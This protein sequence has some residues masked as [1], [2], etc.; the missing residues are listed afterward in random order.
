MLISLHRRLVFLAMTKTASTSIEEALLPLCHISF[1]RHPK[2]KHISYV[3]YKRFVQPYLEEIGFSG[4]ETTCLIREPIS[5][6][7]SWYKYR[8]RQEILGQPESTADTSFDDFATAY[9]TER[10]DFAQFGRQA[11]FISDRKARPAVDHIYRYENLPAFAK[12]LESRFDQ[13]FEFNHLNPSPEREFSLSP[14]VKKHL[15][16]YLAPEYEI[17]ESARGK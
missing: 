11:R 15:E 12:F 9:L 17:Y 16:E 13:P 4:F 14:D 1:Y 5:W 8:S 3:R 7:F 2:V 6:V 10:K